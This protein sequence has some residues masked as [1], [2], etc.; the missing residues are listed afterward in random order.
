MMV[1]GSTNLFRSLRSQVPRDTHYIYHS[2]AYILFMNLRKHEK[3]AT[4]S[5]LFISSSNIWPC[6]FINFSS[7]DKAKFLHQNFLW[8]KLSY[9]WNILKMFN[10]AENNFLGRHS[11]V[12]H[13]MYCCCKAIIFFE[14]N[15][16]QWFIVLKSEVFNPSYRTSNTKVIFFLNYSL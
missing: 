11:L 6:D 12:I 2:K 15:H 7:R 13:N 14:E 5:T 16:R 9:D 8:P 4:V 3:L 10:E 1:R